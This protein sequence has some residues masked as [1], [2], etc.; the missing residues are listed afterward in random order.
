MKRIMASAAAATLLAAGTATPALAAPHA[1]G[2]GCIPVED[3]CMPVN[4]IDEN[5]EI[6][7]GQKPDGSV[8]GFTGFASFV[9]WADDTYG[10]HLNLRGNSVHVDLS[11]PSG[12][13]SDGDSDRGDGDS[14]DRGDGDDRGDRGDGENRNGHGNDDLAGWSARRAD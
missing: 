9:D 6:Y 14:G 10:V 1:A 11:T 13:D 8:Q 3:S 5:T 2:W 7:V 4:D 12:G